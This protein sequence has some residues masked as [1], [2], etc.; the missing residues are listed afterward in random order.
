SSRTSRPLFFIMG[1]LVKSNR[2]CGLKS[3]ISASLSE[4]PVFRSFAGS[5]HGWQE[6]PP[7]TVTDGGAGNG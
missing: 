4:R 3:E 2:G 5:C 6:L 7:P 1:V